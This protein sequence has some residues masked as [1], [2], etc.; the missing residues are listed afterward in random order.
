MQWHRVPREVRE[1]PSLGVF[2]R[3]EDVAVRDVVSG[4]GEDGLVLDLG[5]SV[6]FSNLNDSMSAKTVHIQAG[7]RQNNPTL[8]ST[9][10]YPQ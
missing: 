8:F 1:S 4:H 10:P 9:L 7:Q 5:I 2:Q 6:V 3:C